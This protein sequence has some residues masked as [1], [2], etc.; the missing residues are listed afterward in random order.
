MDPVGLA[1]ALAL[2]R[3]WPGGSQLCVIRR[4]EVVVD[5]AVHCTR[6]SLFMLFSAG[7]P[8]VA[9]LI[10]LL[11]ERGALSLDDPLARHWPEYAR[12]GKEPITVR[13]VLQHRAGVPLASGTLLGDAA[14]MTDWTRS[15]RLAEQARPRWPAGQVPG[16]H[17]ITFGFLLGEVARRVGGAPVDELIRTELL[18]PAGLADI[19]PRLPGTLWPRHVALRTTGG[20]LQRGVLT[21]PQLFLNRRTLRTSVIPA[22]NV[23]A[24]A[25]G[26][27]G[28]YQMLL[29]GGESAGRRVLSPETVARMREP[30]TAPG[31]K[32]RVLRLP[33]RWSQGFQLGGAGP[34]G[35]R[36]RDHPMGALGSPETFGHNGSY[37]CNAWADPTRQL[38]FAYTTSALAARDD[39]ARQQCAVSDAVLSACR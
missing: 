15:V 32:D 18:G 17:V 10:H 24:T 38:V 29:S 3:T 37:Y 16:Y 5:Y 4:G 13:H 14:W 20:P 26:L 7:K 33:I 28:F 23:A 1:R 36:P 6:D 22:A 34:G 12:N 2:V 11:V 25:R 39:A 27:A 21:A 19:H 8:L 31:E 35:E 9:V 30:S